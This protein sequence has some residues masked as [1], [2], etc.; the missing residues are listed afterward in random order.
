MTAPGSSGERNRPARSW[1]IRPLVPAAVTGVVA[2][3]ALVALTYPSL[4]Y[5]WNWDDLHLVR[6]FSMA[7]LLG[8]LTGTWTPD[9]FETLGLRPLTTLFNHLRWMVFGESVEAH[10]L[11]LIGLFAV[12]LGGLGH[13]ASRLGARPWIGVLAGVITVCAKNSYYH[14]VWISDGIH[15]FQALFVLVA[16]FAALSYAESGRPRALLAAGACMA[17]ALLARE[18]S[19]IGFPVLVMITAYA[20]W[21]RGQPAWIRRSTRMG[22]AFSAIFLVIWVWRLAAVPSAPQTKFTL[23]SVGHVW[24]MVLWTI[25]LAG[26]HSAFTP[27][28]AALSI[29][30]VAAALLWLEPGER[31]LAL[32]WLLF[33]AIACIPG[34]VRARTNLLLFAVSFYAT[35]AAIV[36]SAAWRRSRPVAIA[37]CGVVALMVLAPAQASRLEQVSLHPMSADQLRRDWQFVFGPFRGATVPAVRIAVLEPKLRRAGVTAPDFAFDPWLRDLRAKNRVGFRDDGEVF[38]PERPFLSP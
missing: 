14:V 34:N 30:L 23:A 7:E 24:N 25:G 20:G 6:R 10:R 27:V 26:Q 38:V 21:T 17:C 1:W 11:F 35:F 32:L 9:G 29:A 18:D 36:L 8:T 37:V 31:N 28:F 33:A 12:Y 22:I 3:A 4:E 2:A 5:Y 15:L 16:A 19:L 13:L